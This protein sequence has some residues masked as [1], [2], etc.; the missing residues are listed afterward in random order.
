MDTVVDA[1]K[2]VISEAQVMAMLADIDTVYSTRGRTVTHLDLMGDK[3]DAAALRSALIGPRG[4]LRAPAIRKGRTLY[5]GFERGMYKS[6][7]K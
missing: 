1:K 5:I 2:H 3:P 6:M 7:M 4:N